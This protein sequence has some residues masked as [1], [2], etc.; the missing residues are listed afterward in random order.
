[1]KLLKGLVLGVS[2]FYASFTSASIMVWLDPDFQIGHTGD[3][4]SVTL[5]VGGLGDFSARSLGAFDL[6]L[7]FD[8]TVLSFTGYDLFG[9]LG[10]I[11]LFEA[12][13]LSVGEYAPGVIGLA[14]L[15]YLFDFELIALQADSFALAEV[16]FDISLLED[17]DFTHISIVPFAFSDEVGLA[18]TDIDV[19]GATIATRDVPEPASIL[20]LGI[21]LF[22]LSRKLKNN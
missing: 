17:P 20:L 18:F 5:M 1:M 4:V 15:S 19:R 10:D 22:G 13:D 9:D 16:F 12:D 7:I 14:E 2:L 6:D 8:P 11:G 21:G 3:S